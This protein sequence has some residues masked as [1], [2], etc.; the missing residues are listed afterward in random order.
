VS[1]DAS[2]SGRMEFF[3][4][5]VLYLNGRQTMLRFT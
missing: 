1:Q 3:K 2:Q 4:N 5:Q